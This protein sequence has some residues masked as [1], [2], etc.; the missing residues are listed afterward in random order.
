MVSSV[1]GCWIAVLDCG[2]VRLDGD[3]SQKDQ[4]E[5]IKDCKVRE[6]VQQN[7]GLLFVCKVVKHKNFDYHRSMNV[8]PNITQVASLIGE[9][10]RSVILETLLDGR[11]L[12]ASELAH[13]AGVSLQTISSHL[14]KLL[15]GQLLS[16][17]THGRHRYYRLASEQVAHALEALSLLSP[18]VKVTSLRQ[19]DTLEG[20]RYARTCYDHLAGKL[21]VDVTQ[22]LVTKGFIQTEGKEYVITRKGEDWF[23]SI[24]IDVHRLKAG[25][26]VFCRQCLD[27]SERRYH[28]SGAVGAALAAKLFELAWITK[29]SSSRAVLITEQGKKELKRVLDLEV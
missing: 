10:T 1:F 4:G 18:P 5:K 12:P 2:A 16:A 26:R 25:R 21:G 13:I 15:E 24:G 14:D 27:W 22:A 28:M 9:K 6:E 11:A 3:E 8:Y 7:V 29:T 17:E 23:Q 19:S 20:V